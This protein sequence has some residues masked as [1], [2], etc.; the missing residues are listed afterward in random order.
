MKTNKEKLND[1]VGMLDGE[2]VQTA[3]TRAAD[4]KASRLTRRAT[5]RR[6]AVI[7][8][9]A[10]LSLTL[11][12]G[13]LLAIPL[14][15]AED[16][17]IPETVPQTPIPPATGE[18][19]DSFYTEVPLVRLT[20]LTARDD[21]TVSEAPMISRGTQSRMD[22]VYGFIQPFIIM[23]FD[24]EEGET[25]TVNAGVDSLYLVSLPFTEDTDLSIAGSFMDYLI[26]IYSANDPGSRT[27][28]I[29]PTTACILVDMPL[30]RT[31]LDED[32]MTF[33]VTGE[34]G[35][36]VGAGSVYV[37]TRYFLDAE[38]HRLWYEDSILTRS[39]VLGSVRFD[40]PEEVTAEQVSELLG[41]FVAKTEEAKA[42]LDYTPATTEERFAAAQA[43]IATTVFDG[44]QIHGSSSGRSAF[45]YFRIV[46]VSGTDKSEKNRAFLIFADGTWAE[47]RVHN[48]CFAQC[49]GYA[50]PMGED[51][52]SHHALVTGCRIT[53]LDG[54]VFEIAEQEID[55]KMMRVP[56]LI[57]QPAP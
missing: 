52:D 48:D 6:R 10:C 38:A 54:R 30:T 40:T 15:T 57:S 37:G 12:L 9:A 34:D 35:A 14:M 3:M 18:N 13:A 28:T 27:L 31:D 55:G 4:M 16:P 1:A 46:S 36:T 21:S 39:A 41:S 56:V 23:S 29:D 24:C 32:T 20:Q 47:F 11:M 51:G 26:D 42:E 5:L 25:V 2:T 44:E 53:L 19:P 33:T 8:L 45:E 49:H 43:E 17:A 7:L 22:S 50:C